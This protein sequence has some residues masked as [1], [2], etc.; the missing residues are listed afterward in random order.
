MI[1]PPYRVAYRSLGTYL[2][3]A[4]LTGVCSCWSVHNASTNHRGLILNH[5]WHF[6]PDQAT[7]FYWTIGGITGVVSVLF[8]LSFLRDLI[9]PQY[10]ELTE[11]E[12]RMYRS[13]FAMGMTKVPYAAITGVSERIVTSRAS[14]K[15]RLIGLDVRFSNRSVRIIP[16]RLPNKQAYLEVIQ[17]LANRAITSR[18]NPALRSVRR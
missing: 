6:T 7:T 13:S 12:M 5:I 9:A 10:F 11:T 16:G 17:F 1:K 18:S 4:L 3:F 2:F 14:G 8:S 15:T